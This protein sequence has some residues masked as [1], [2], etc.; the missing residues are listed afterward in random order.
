MEQSRTLVQITSC[1]LPQFMEPA[2]L[3]K[4]RAMQEMLANEWRTIRHRI[5]NAFMHGALSRALL[6]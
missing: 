5:S 3:K 1:E 6:G 4:G 2:N